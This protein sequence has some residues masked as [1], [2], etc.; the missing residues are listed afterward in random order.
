MQVAEYD[1]IPADQTVLGRLRLLDLDH[2]VCLAVH[3]LG[4][5]DERGA[6]AAEVCVRKAGRLA[7]TG[8][9]KYS[10]SLSGQQV[11]LVRRQRYPALVG[12]NLVG[13]PNDHQR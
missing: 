4:P 12:H 3:I 11:D 13:D 10:V 1:L 2:H 6:R 9:D 7:G 5:P 8:L